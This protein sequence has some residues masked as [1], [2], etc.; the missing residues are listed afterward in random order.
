METQT[1]AILVTHSIRSW[2]QAR[3]KLGLHVWKQ[4]DPIGSHADVKILN[5]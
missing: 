3:A 2:P 1:C 5:F 4:A